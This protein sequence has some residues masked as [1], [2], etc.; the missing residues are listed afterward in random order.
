LVLD[1]LT[2]APSMELRMPAMETG[3]PFVFNNLRKA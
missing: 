1:A 3:A 2:F